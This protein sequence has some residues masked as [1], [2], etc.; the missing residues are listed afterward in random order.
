MLSGSSQWKQTRIVKEGTMYLE[1]NIY[2]QNV[3]YIPNMNCTLVFVSKIDQTSRTLIRVGHP[4]KQVFAYLLEVHGGDS[5][6]FCDSCYKA[7]QTS[8]VF[9]DSYNKADAKIIISD[10]ETKFTCLRSYFELHGILYQTVSV[11]T[12]QQMRVERKHW[13]ILNVVGALRF[14]ANLPIQFWEKCVFIV[15]LA[16]LGN[17]RVEGLDYNKTFALIAKMTTMQTS[18]SG[19]NEKLGVTS[20]KCS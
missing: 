16:I 13:H 11:E 5:F 6:D 14:Q 12:L 7:K 9:Q 4:S 3:L 15:Q 20:N 10:N 18:I 8:D 2:L 19:N 1:E 17:R